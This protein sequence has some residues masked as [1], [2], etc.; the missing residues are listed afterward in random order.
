VVTISPFI[1]A[2]TGAIFHNCRFCHMLQEFSMKNECI[3]FGWEWDPWS[4]PWSPNGTPVWPL[5][6]LFAKRH[7]IIWV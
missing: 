3:N 7:I 4:P 1:L 5:S 6:F 2:W